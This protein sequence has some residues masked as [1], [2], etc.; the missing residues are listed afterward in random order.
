MLYDQPKTINKIFG[1]GLKQILR[2]VNLVIPKNKAVSEIGLVFVSPAKMAELN[3][4]YRRCN[5]PTNVLSFETGFLTTLPP[6]S[7]LRRASGAGDIVICPEVAKAEA[8]ESGFTQ[9]YWMTHL[10]VH[11]ILHLAGYGHERPR[12]IL[13]ME[14][15]EREALA[16][17]G[18]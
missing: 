13:D 7:R 10:V 18:F 8:K 14:K 11:G 4:K 3:L 15:A 2:K 6:S 5:K 1:V 16:L 12:D 17:L 9:K